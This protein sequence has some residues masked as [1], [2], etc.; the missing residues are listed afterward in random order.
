M[1]RIASA[2]LIRYLKLSPDR[3]LELARSNNHAE[4]SRVGDYTLTVDCFFDD[5]Q[6]ERAVRILVSVNRPGLLSFM[7][8]RSKAAIAG[9]THNPR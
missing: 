3:L 1:D 9:A 5:P 8:P 4:V 7:F 6:H 2:A